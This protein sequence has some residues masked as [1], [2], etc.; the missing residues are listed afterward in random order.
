MD[1]Y[2]CVD[3]VP[4]RTYSENSFVRLLFTFTSMVESEILLM[5]E[6]LAAGDPHFQKKM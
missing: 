2:S 4:I 3:N 5:D 6:C 1:F